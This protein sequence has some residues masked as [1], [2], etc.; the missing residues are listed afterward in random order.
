L[1]LIFRDE[2][3]CTALLLAAREGYANIVKVLMD[4]YG[5]V[6]QSDKIKVI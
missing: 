6:N 5:E 2:N 4:N 3:F 1:H